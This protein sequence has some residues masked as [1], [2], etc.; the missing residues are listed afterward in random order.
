MKIALLA[1]ALALAGCG[2]DTTGGVS[3]D[4]AQP[5]LDIAQPGTVCGASVCHGGCT[6]CINFGGGVCVTP[7]NMAAPSCPSGTCMPLSPSDGGA[8]ASVVLSG[9]CA[10]F[11]GYC[12]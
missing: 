12:G 3:M 1:L 7:C 11:D 8:G 5:V 4:M 9:S 6:G 10:G 2:D